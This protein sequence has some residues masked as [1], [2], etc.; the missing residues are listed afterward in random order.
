MIRSVLGS[1]EL[2]GKIEINKD[3]FIFSTENKIILVL[4][5]EALNNKPGLMILLYYW[6]QN[7]YLLWVA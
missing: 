4:Q 3:Y 5:K 1:D 7:Y 6:A 2:W